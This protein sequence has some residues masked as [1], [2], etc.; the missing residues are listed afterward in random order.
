MFRRSLT[1]LIVLFIAAATA[2]A[3]FV[4]SPRA[5]LIHH[6]DGEVLVE[7]QV[8]NQDGA[9]FGWVGEGK[10][11]RTGDAGYC[12]IVLAPGSVLWVGPNSSILLLSDDITNIQLELLSG[13]SIID[14]SSGPEDRPIRLA[15]SESQIELHKRGHY[16]F[17]VY[18][19][20]AAQLRV[21]EG[22]AE[23]TYE[24]VSVEAHDGQ[25]ITL[26]SE[27]VEGFD[28]RESDSF[29]AWHEERAQFIEDVN[30]LARTP[31]QRLVDG[32]RGLFRHLASGQS[33]RGPNPF[34]GSRKYR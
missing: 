29:D 8:L 7:D 25:V 4:I 3:Q 33:N 19:D 22:Q 32:F 14:W 26:G 27:E 23:L 34:A 18:T 5:G 24:G 11:L 28:T 17:D 2:Q 20:R 1:A 10:I 15:H 30:N 9:A 21:Y 13:S 12:E 16:R 6:L 31:N